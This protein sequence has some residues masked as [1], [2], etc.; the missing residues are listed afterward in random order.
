[1]RDVAGA[2]RQRQRRRLREVAVHDF[3]GERV[4]MRI[5]VGESDRYGG[6]P[7]YQAIV[8]L[9]RERGYAGATVLKS[10]MGFGASRRLHS[11][12]NEIAS[13][14]MPLV[15][16]CVET[17]ERIEAILPELDAMLAGGVITLERANVVVYRPGG[18]TVDG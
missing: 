7:V 16:E 11:R 3:V 1:V 4:L 8:E 18:T 13:L 15:V 14:D 12:V 5:H 2:S 10:I 9:L 6:R 17:A